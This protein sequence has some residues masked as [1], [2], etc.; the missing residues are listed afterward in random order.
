MISSREDNKRLGGFQIAPGISH[1]DQ[2][3]KKM[4][5]TPFVVEQALF[6]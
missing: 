6:S 5:K 4:T 1:N 2:A 3:T